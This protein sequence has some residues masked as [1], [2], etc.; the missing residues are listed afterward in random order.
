[1]HPAFPSPTL[2]SIESAVANSCLVSEGGRRVMGK[3]GH[4]RNSE[5]ASSLR[6]L[7][8]VGSGL[9]GD[10]APYLNNFKFK[11]FKISYFKREKRGGKGGFAGF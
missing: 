3:E 7:R 9:G 11:I 10:A 2:Y 5:S 6:R 8:G 4:G 1:M